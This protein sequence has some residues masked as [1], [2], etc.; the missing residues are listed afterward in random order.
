MSNNGRY[1]GING[2]LDRERSLAIKL[3]IFFAV[4]MLILCITGVTIWPAIL[5][6][7]GKPTS[8]GILCK[9]LRLANVILLVVYVVLTTL[10]VWFD[11]GYTFLKNFI[12]NASVGWLVNFCVL[13]FNNAFAQTELTSGVMIKLLWF[14]LSVLLGLVISI[15]PA[16][17]V[18][19]I[20]KALHAG[21][22][23]YNR[24]A[25]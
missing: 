25:G 4:L 20:A 23:F 10:L 18:A 8:I 2:F 1:G 16:A 22:N 13:L 14:T 6:F 15:V 7:A 17:I 12:M 19:G 21:A 24:N 11:N 5:A 9:A 3:T